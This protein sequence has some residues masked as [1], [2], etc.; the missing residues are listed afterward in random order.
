MTKFPRCTIAALAA[1]TML[2]PMAAM[3]GPCSDDIAAVGKQL[4]QSA[5]MG[6]VTSG[7]LSGSNAVANK[8]DDN[9]VTGSN[10][11]GTSADKHVGGTA[12]TKEMNAA[13]SNVATSDADVR[14]QQ[15]GHPTATGAAM[16]GDRSS[17]TET[18][19]KGTMTSQASDDHVSKA[20]ADWQ[21]AVDLNA[22]NDASCKGAIDQAK[23]DM[24]RG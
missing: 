6:P 4:S 11:K 17:S 5:A 20:K 23:Q 22:K 13:S 8:A 9:V 7:T 3:A 2:W 15:S 12:G 14:Q 1:S 18:K 21:K 19:P 16:S 24:Q 10:Q